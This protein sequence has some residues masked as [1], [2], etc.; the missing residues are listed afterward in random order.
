[1]KKDGPKTVERMWPKRLGMLEESCTDCELLILL[2]SVH[3]HLFCTNQFSNPKCF[4]SWM[5]I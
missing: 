3:K 4:E 2:T 5:G 1:M